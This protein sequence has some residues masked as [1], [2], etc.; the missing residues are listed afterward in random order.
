[1]SN[2]VD[3]EER[4]SAFSNRLNTFRVKNVDCKSVSEF[5]EEAFIFFE[6]MVESL[7]DI[8][9]MMKVS[10]CFHA[11]FEK[12]VMS[13]DGIENVVTQPMYLHSNAEIIDFESNLRQ[14]YVK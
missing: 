2:H 8:H 11:I 10:V 7:L 14:I 5:F 3:I 1:M 12:K 13:N 6:P 9:Y 4:E